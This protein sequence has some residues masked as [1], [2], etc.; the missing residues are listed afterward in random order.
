MQDLHVDALRYFVPNPLALFS[1]E[2]HLQ[3]QMMS[4]DHSFGIVENC[5]HND[6]PCKIS[7]T[8]SICFTCKY[9]HTYMKPSIVQQMYF[10]FLAN[11]LRT[12]I[13]K[14]FSPLRSFQCMLAVDEL[15]QCL[16]MP[17][18]IPG[19][20]LVTVSTCFIHAGRTYPAQ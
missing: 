6:A 7:D 17:V 8:Y 11:F 15:P 18:L 4:A 2:G 10:D 13:I 9:H 5:S 1:S 20:R 3:L 12:F 16:K 14:E 19:P